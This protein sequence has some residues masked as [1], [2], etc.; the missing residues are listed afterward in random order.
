MTRCRVIATVK[1]VQGKCPLYKLG[2]RI[3]FEGFYVKSNESND[4]CIHAFAAMSTL[5]SAFL[6]GTLA[7]DLG[8]GVEPDV[9]YVQCPDPGPPYT[10]GGKVIFELKRQTDQA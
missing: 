3:V 10:K 9:G 7:K 4:V 8:I 1:E 2:D 5:L 6:H